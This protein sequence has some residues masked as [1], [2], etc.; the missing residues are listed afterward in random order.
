MFA[1]RVLQLAPWHDGTCSSSEPRKAHI[2]A[3]F[4][5]WLTLI[6]PHYIL[7]PFS[8]LVINAVA[9]VAIGNAVIPTIVGAVITIIEAIILAALGS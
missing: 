6:Y 7:L 8:T 1:L 4:T 2:G 3:T 9:V 5:I